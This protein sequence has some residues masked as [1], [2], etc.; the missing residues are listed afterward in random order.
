MYHFVSRYPFLLR[1]SSK[2]LCWP[3]HP[4]NTGFG[5]LRFSSIPHIHHIHMYSLSTSMEN[6]PFPTPIIIAFMF[7]SFLV[8]SSPL[9]SVAR[10]SPI[11]SGFSSSNLYGQRSQGV[12]TRVP[13][14]RSLWG[15][16]LGKP[17]FVDSDSAV[18]RPGY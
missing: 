7:P 9:L 14:C 12:T 18:L 16:S 6:W 17:R 1:S 13:R 11:I 3:I 5:Q 10:S 8:Y 4:R 15:G 2:S